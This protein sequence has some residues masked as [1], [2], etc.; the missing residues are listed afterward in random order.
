MNPFKLL[1]GALAALAGRT[2]PRELAA[3]VALGMSLALIP[4]A[5]L[6]AQLLLALLFI[7]KINTG[8]ALASSAAFLLATPLT[9]PLADAIGYLLLVKAGWL[10]PFWT[11][12]Y[13]LPVVPWTSFNN[14]LVLG[15]A[16]LAALLFIPVYLAARA[17]ITRYQEQIRRA[18]G[19]W[20]IVQALRASAFLR[21]LTPQ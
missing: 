17:G 21:R 1:R 19:R 9:D 3:A 7:L 20:K 16:V 8:L 14:T 4:K 2:E 13:D 10:T 15:N 12:L 11:R 5:N 18:V 6:L